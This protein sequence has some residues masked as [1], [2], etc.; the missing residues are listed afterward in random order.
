M[1]VRAG[2]YYFDSCSVIF[3]SRE[4]PLCPLKLLALRYESRCVYVYIHTHTHT[5]NKKLVEL[6]IFIVPFA[7][8][9]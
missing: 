4:K 1:L 6:D 3:G 9:T 8:Q 7:N 5:Q 2:G